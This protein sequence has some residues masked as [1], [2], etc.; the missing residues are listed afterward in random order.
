LVTIVDFGYHIKAIFH[1]QCING[2][3]FKKRITLSKLVVY[4]KLMFHSF[5]VPIVL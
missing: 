4:G 2:M 3:L 5:W 1:V